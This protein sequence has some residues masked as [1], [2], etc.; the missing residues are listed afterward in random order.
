MNYVSKLWKK[1]KENVQSCP[2][3]DFLS[4]MECYTKDELK[5]YYLEVGWKWGE[6]Q[7][8]D[9]ANGLW[10]VEWDTIYGRHWTRYESAEALDKAIADNNARYEA[11]LLSEYERLRKERSERV[12]T[13]R[14]S[15]NTLGNLFPDLNK[16]K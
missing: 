10:K 1:A 8:E 2:W 12:K 14:E 6:E 4:D 13:Q 16:L 5:A 7:E 15:R 9:Y 11:E 3:I